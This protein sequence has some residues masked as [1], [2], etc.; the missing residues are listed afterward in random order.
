MAM[1][2][3]GQGP[4]GD[5]PLLDLAVA[6]ALEKDSNTSQDALVSVRA[7]VGKYIQGLLE[8]HEA[9][10]LINAAIG[11]N[12]V[13]N[14]IDEILRTPLTP[15]PRPASDASEPNPTGRAHTRPWSQY[16]DQ[17]LIAGIHRFGYGDWG[18]VADFVGNER[19]KSQC[20]QR[21]N[22]GLDP[23]IDKSRWTPAQDSRLLVLAAQYGE[24]SWSKIS[25]GMTSRSDVQC[26]YRFHQ[27]AK[28]ANFEATFDEAKEISRRLS[29]GGGIGA[30]PPAQ[31]CFI[32]SYPPPVQIVHLIPVFPPPFG[33][34]GKPAV[35]NAAGY[36]PCPFFAPSPIARPV[37]F[38]ASG[39]SEMIQCR[40]VMLPPP[41][42]RSTES[43]PF[44]K[45]LLAGSR[46]PST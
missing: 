14:R 45:Q 41:R 22:R 33:G 42:I 35:P 4:E 29:R 8:F 31:S 7:A 2:A 23:T 36:E 21:W 11:W 30:L 39:S 26:R 28:S 40:P 18:S 1:G 17:R 12:Q 13:L 19:T 5:D 44:A 6:Y 32:P 38:L 24:G 25:A 15:I 9:A 37:P 16:E 46:N 43:M 10:L 27:L 34:L 3:P 20:Y